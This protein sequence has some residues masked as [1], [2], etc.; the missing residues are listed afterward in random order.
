MK[1]SGFQ[2]YL[3]GWDKFLSELASKSSG[4]AWLLSLSGWD[5]FLRVL[6]RAQGRCSFS[7]S[8]HGDSGGAAGSW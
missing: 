4:L 6:E 5:K 8:A 3:L 1:Y 2:V 7:G